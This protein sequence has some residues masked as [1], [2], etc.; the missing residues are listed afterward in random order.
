MHGYL[1]ASYG[2]HLARH[3]PYQ[4]HS[5]T[6]R[7]NLNNFVNQ[8]FSPL[9]NHRGFD[10]S[11]RREITISGWIRPFWCIDERIKESWKKSSWIGRQWWIKKKI[12]RKRERKRNVSRNCFSLKRERERERIIKN[13]RR[14]YYT[15]IIYQ[16]IDYFY[17]IKMKK[18]FDMK[19]CNWILVLE[20]EKYSPFK[21]T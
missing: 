9:P 7:T 2:E 14:I 4:N 20:R 1:I 3:M 21:E 13:A 19:I 18:V 11:R 5:K 15:T 17:S 10:P 6:R 12:G 8:N 16:E